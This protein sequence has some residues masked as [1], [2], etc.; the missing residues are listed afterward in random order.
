MRTLVLMVAMAGLVSTA[1]ADFGIAW[2]RWHDGD[3][4]CAIEV[5]SEGNV[6]VGGTSGAD[7]L[8]IKYSSYGDTLWVRSLDGGDNDEFIGLA[9][10]ESDNVLVAGTSFG[11]GFDADYMTA[12]YSPAGNLLW[13]RKHNG[14]G[15]RLD[16]AHAM[17]VD[18][19]GCVYVTGQSDRESLGM[20]RYEIGTVKYLPN[21][22]TAWAR[23]HGLSGSMPMASGHGLGADRSGNVYVTGDAGSLDGV[24]DYLTIKYAADGDTVWT[25]TYDSPGGD[26]DWPHALVVDRSGNAIVT[27]RGGDDFA[28]VKYDPEG[29]ELWAATY[30]RGGTDEARSLDVDGSGAVYVAGGASGSFATVKYSP[31]G[32]REWST[33]QLGARACDVAVDDSAYVYVCGRGSDGY[34]TAVYDSAGEEQWAMRYIGMYQT[35]ALAVAP[36]EQGDVYV[37]GIYWSSSGRDILTIKY[38]E[39]VG[40]ELRP[41]ARPEKPEPRVLMVSRILELPDGVRGK[42]LDLSGRS[43]AELRPGENDIRHAAPGVYFIREGSRVQGFEGPSRKVVIQR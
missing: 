20:T 40:V 16:A 1:Q 14:I 9:V 43:V 30:D 42:L 37:T 33:T 27:G 15:R 32:V 36:D 35:S 6:I 10:D 2:Q 21:G 31:A 29:V 22:D 4:A 24:F 3:S 5:D 11:P 39:D 34:L 25:R 26:D 8:V 13:M 12:K 7:F 28:T 19:S 23:A 38:S 18:D 17:C 41:A